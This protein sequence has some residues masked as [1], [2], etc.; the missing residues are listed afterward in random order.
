MNIPADLKYTKTDEWVKVEGKF[1][2]IGVTD[3]AQQQLSDIVFIEIAPAKGDIVKKH[4]TFA[5]V[6]SVK[7][8]ADVNLPVSGKV[9]E[10]NESLSSTPEA[11]NSDPFG[12][13]WMMKVELTNSGE[14]S[15]LMDA[16]AYEVYCQGRSH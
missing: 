3:Y 16:K 5:T 12:K 8:A 15:E 10:V 6:E 9:L 7:A 4:T 13:A 11:I 2:T 1:A 14:L